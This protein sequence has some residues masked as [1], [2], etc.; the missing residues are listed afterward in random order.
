LFY[1]NV[2]SALICFS[3]LSFIILHYIEWQYT[4]G[5]DRMLSRYWS[6]PPPSTPYEF[7]IFWEVICCTR[8]LF[9]CPKGDLLILFI[10]MFDCNMSLKIYRVETRFSEWFT[11]LVSVVRMFNKAQKPYMYVVFH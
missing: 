5:Y 8:Q 1:N 9:L 6:R 11:W 10:Y 4:K 7:N 2:F 3:T